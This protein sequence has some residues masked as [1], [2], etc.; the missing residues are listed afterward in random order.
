MIFSKREAQLPCCL[1]YEHSKQARAP[2]TNEPRDVPRCG[3]LSVL[4]KPLHYT[5]G[6][7][8]GAQAIVRSGRRSLCCASQVLDHGP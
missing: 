8:R 3:A 5:G 1:N 4:Q 6:G 2:H 7:D